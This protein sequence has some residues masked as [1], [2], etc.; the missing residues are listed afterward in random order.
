[1]ATSAAASVDGI[2]VLAVAAVLIVPFLFAL[3]LPAITDPAAGGR[4][5]VALIAAVTAL[6]LLL[7]GVAVWAVRRR[8]DTLASIGVVRPHAAWAAVAVVIAAGAGWLIWRRHT[9]AWGGATSSAGAG[10]GDYT[11]AQQ[12][13]LVAL[14]IPQIYLQEL[15]YRGF[16]ITFLE[17]I[18]GSLAAAVAIS[19][20]AF[21]LAHITSLGGNL[22]VSL[23]AVFVASVLFSLLYAAT[24]DL[25]PVF[26]IHWAWVAW[27]V[28]GLSG[29]TA[30]PAKPTVPA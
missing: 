9:G 11:T 18:T 10:G 14:G 5:G 12:I 1:M 4:Q 29:H 27:L 28:V 6:E 3:A 2:E 22:L 17:R 30:A 8:G 16:A 19:S 25:M 20:V 13:T 26:V 21:A 7:A 24:R 23:F 15:L